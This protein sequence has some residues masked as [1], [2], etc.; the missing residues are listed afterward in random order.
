MNVGTST[1][2]GLSDTW[3]A[4]RGAGEMSER[5]VRGDLGSGK[6]SDACPLLQILNRERVHQ[7]E[8]AKQSRDNKTFSE[9][10]A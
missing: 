1:C 2:P 8:G 9:H 4:I 6:R 3:V 5:P 10:D 7:R